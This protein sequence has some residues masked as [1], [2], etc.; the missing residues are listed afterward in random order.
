MKVGL[1][2]KKEPV[3]QNAIVFAPVFEDVDIG[4]ADQ[5]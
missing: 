2:K 3:P 1:K 5:N 4:G